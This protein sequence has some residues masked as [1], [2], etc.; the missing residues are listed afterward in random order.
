MDDQQTIGQ[1]N[2]RPERR[3][4]TQRTSGP[5]QYVRYTDRGYDGT[6]RIFFEFTLPSGQTQLDPAIYAV[7]RE[8]K[9]NENG[10]T[11]GLVGSSRGQIWSLPDHQHG[12]G[13]ADRLDVALQELAHK[14]E[15]D[16]RRNR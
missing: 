16:S 3:P 6:R 13:T 10:H 14:L 12:R 1:P 9:K 7:M 15:N 5:V 2:H 11:T 4:W 8:H